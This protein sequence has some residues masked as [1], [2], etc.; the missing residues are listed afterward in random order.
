MS[1]LSKIINE[2]R[3]RIAELKSDKEALDRENSSLANLVKN[4][5]K[6]AEAAERE[7]DYHEKTIE[8]P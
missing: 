8:V 2:Q 6:R 1:E 5:V 3:E 4:S 7:R